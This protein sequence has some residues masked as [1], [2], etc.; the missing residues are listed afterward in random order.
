MHCKHAIAPEPGGRE[1]EVELVL[2]R[3]ESLSEGSG[4]PWIN[5]EKHLSV[6]SPG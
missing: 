4:F 3:L 2:W 5:L 6:A 1:L